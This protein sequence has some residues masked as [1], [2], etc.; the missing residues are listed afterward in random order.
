MTSEASSAVEL[1]NEASPVKPPRL[2]RLSKPTPPTKED[3]KKFKSITQNKSVDV[4]AIDFNMS[5]IKVHTKTNGDPPVSTSSEPSSTGLSANLAHPGLTFVTSV[6]M[7]ADGQS[8]F[9]LT[10]STADIQAISV[11]VCQYIVDNLNEIMSPLITS[12][13]EQLTT[14]L[15]TATAEIVELRSE[16]ERL[17][18]K[19]DDLEQFNRRNF[20]RISGVPESSN[21]DNT[22]DTTEVVVNLMAKTGVQIATT[23][24]EQ[25]YR[26]GKRNKQDKTVKRP[27]IVKFTNYATKKLSLKSKKKLPKGVY[28]NDDLTKNRSTVAYRARCLVKSRAAKSTWTDDGKIFLIDNADVRHIV[29]T[30]NT[31]DEL[32]KNLPPYVPPG[33]SVATVAAQPPPK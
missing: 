12:M 6:P 14:A 25:S 27:I 23:D 11:N 15:N 10:L 24:V 8:A 32:K 9:Q 31:L 33:P 13:T 5:N 18:A 4:P 20:V 1:T 2:R 3:L 22:E 19:V 28:I 16:N 21:I 17:S 29:T 7:P 26:I 30:E